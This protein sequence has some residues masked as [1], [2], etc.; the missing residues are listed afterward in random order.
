MTTYL[1]SFVLT[2]LIGAMLAGSSAPLSHL[3]LP[4]PPDPDEIEYCEVEYDYP[5]PIRIGVTASSFDNVG[6]ILRHFGDGVDFY[7]VSSRDFANIDLLSG[8]YAIFINC[9]SHQQVNPRV[10]NTFVYNGGVV[11]ASDHAGRALRSAFPGM[12]DFF[13]NNSGQMVYDADITH[14][15]LASHMRMDTI[16][17]RFNMGGW[18][19]IT[20]LSDCAT[21]YIE[22]VLR[23][24]EQ[25]PLA[26][27]FNYGAGQ[28]F[29]TSFHNSAQATFN[30]INFIEYLIFRIKNVEADRNF[31][32][33]AEREGFAYRGQVFGGAG[34]AAV[35]MAPPAPMA[36][37]APMPTPAPGSAFMPPAAQAPGLTGLDSD[38]ADDIQITIA[39][40]D[41]P[42]GMAPGPAFAPPALWEE[43][44]R[45]T[46]T[47]TGFMLMINPG[48][49]G[50]LYY[51]TLID[52]AG[53]RFTI[54]RDGTI[55]TDAPADQTPDITLEYN[56]GYRVQVMNFTSGEWQFNAETSNNNNLAIG[57][58]VME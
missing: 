5:A 37:G 23:D 55:I 45:Y 49:G 46:F 16:D 22:G 31:Q 58:A 54:Y 56:D 17:V 2:L 53:N 8:F 27:S 38:W 18:Y 40:D 10:L 29:F 47:G 6:Q 43:Y 30:M 36:D 12:I 21:I 35:A 26:V 57:I 44:F 3:V 34:Q 14:S 39:G 15:T 1:H 28:V 25:T 42:M 33:T 20:E 41:A 7:H 4:P 32:E 51:V 19:S 11:Y 52:P 9:G 13:T 50:T 48:T 24:G